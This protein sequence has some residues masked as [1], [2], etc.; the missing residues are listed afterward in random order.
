MKTA[1]YATA[2]LVDLL[3]S[4]RGGRYDRGITVQGVQASAMS[5]TLHTPD[6]N[7]PFSYAYFGA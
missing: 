6:E 7:D 5:S 3:F 4:H 1:L 2:K